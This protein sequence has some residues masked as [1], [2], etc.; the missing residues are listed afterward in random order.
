MRSSTTMRGMGRAPRAR[1]E[2]EIRWRTSRPRTRPRRAMGRKGRPSLRCLA[3]RD[4]INHGPPGRGAQR[5]SWMSEKDNASPRW[6]RP[7]PTTSRRDHRCGRRAGAK[8]SAHQRPRTLAGTP[9]HLPGGTKAAAVA[10]RMT[11]GLNGSILDHRLLI[12]CLV[13]QLKNFLDLLQP[14]TRTLG[15]RFCASCIG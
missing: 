14:R 8:G 10:G 4:H 3:L 9:M 11:I 13:H 2:D 12:V 5:A 7:G 6:S 1:V 15:W